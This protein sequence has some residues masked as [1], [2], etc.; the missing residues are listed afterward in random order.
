MAEIG[1]D[2]TKLVIFVI[3]D[4]VFCLRLAF[5]SQDN[6]FVDLTQ[7]RRYRYLPAHCVD[8]LEPEP[9]VARDARHRSTVITTALFCDRIALYF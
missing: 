4:D 9:Y 5:E 2:L 7:S 8:I 1:A 6:V 3:R